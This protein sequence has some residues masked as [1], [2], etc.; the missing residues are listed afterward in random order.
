[1]TLEKHSKIFV[2]GHR[3]MV[4]SAMVRRLQAEGCANLALRAKAELD[5][6]RQSEVEYFFKTEKPEVVFMAAARVG[7][8]LANNTCRAEFSYTN[9]AIQTNVIHA[10]WQAGV[11]GLV[12]FSSSSVYPRECPQPMKEEHLFSGSPEPTNEP[13]AM[14]KLAGMSMCRAYRD[15]YG[16]NFTAVILSNLYGPNDNFDPQQSHLLA[17][18][19]RKFHEA[20][21][22]GQKS[23]MLWGTGTPRREMM[24]V[25][26][27]VDAALFVLQHYSGGGPLNVGLG[28]DRTIR[29]INE[30]PHH[31]RRR[32]SRLGPHA[33]APG[34][35]PRSHRARQFLFQPKQPCSTAASSRNSRSSAAIAARNP[36]SSRSSPKRI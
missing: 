15:Q 36:S 35:G 9:L 34:A 22:S 3:G 33:H 21:L 17:A 14:A 23:V 2:A 18:L 31:R 27:A 5:L 11:K 16:A 32:L 28:Q 19:L 29:E 4:G 24:Y 26:D 1:M 10:A 30:N 25:D 6:T 7:G 13:Y 20:K 12:F 8:I